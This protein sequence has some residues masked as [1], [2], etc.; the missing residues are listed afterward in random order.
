MSANSS[1]N[2]R[3]DF[4]LLPATEHEQQLQ[5]ACRLSEKAWR[6]GYTV[7]IELEQDDDV[8]RLDKLL[9]SFKEDAFIPHAPAPGN[10]EPVL[11]A[12]SAPESSSPLEAPRLL[13]RISSTEPKNWQHFARVAELISASEPVRAYGREHYRY[14]Q[15]QGLKPHLHH[16]RG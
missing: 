15:S 6:Q 12:R 11:I 2:A 10:G 14:Y 1:A 8:R 4:Y 5:L 3:I 9:W 7:W 13:I 16:L